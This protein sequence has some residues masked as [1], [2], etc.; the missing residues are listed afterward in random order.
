MDWVT[1]VLIPIW[2]MFSSLLKNVQT[3]SE[4]QRGSCSMDTGVL[5]QDFKSAEA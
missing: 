4:F 5:L 2:K 1:G 3:V